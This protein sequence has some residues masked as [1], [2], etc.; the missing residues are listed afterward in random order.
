MGAYIIQVI[1]FQALFLAV[2]YLLLRKET[3]FVYNRIYLLV[4]PVL[5]LAIPFIKIMTLQAIVPA[6][7]MTTVLP[8]VVIG[9]VS[10]APR[11]IASVSESFY[12]P[13]SALYMTGL[14]VS[15]VL[16]SLKIRK[17]AS[18]LSF[19][20]AG[21]RIIEMPASVE[22]FTFFNYIFI[23][24]DIDPLSQKQI[25]IHE[26]IH[27]K[28]GHTWDLVFFELLKIGFW[29]NPLVY[30]YQKHISIVHEYLADQ[31]ATQGIANKDYYQELL[32]TAF[33]TSN[34]SFINTFFKSS[35]IKNR[36]IMLQ[37]SKSRKSAL[38]KYTLIIPLVLA[39]LVYVSCSEDN[40]TLENQTLEQQIAQLQ[41]AIEEKGELSPEEIE[42][43]IE[44][45]T[46]VY[47]K[48]GDNFNTKRF[49][50]YKSDGTWQVIEKESVGDGNG[51]IPFSVIDEV[52][53]YP[54]CEGLITNEERRRCM[55]SKISSHINSRFN[56]GIAD[57]LGISGTNRIFMS[58]K[59]DTDG[60]IVDLKSRAPHP[61]LSS[62]IERIISTLPPMEPGK[63]KGQAASV[64]YTLP[65]TF[66]VE[67]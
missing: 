58:F 64:L 59:I 57:D 34:F 53:V 31:K 15:T 60:N 32:N 47:N 52:P 27:V 11:E 45:N 9:K 43:F 3:F 54:G 1:C 55:S 21:K 28:Q 63:Q 41:A 8:E 14:M 6:E 25:L 62:E 10:V 38:V 19:K 2:Y 61:G 13:W 18:F 29:F 66:K 20:K 22:A 40:E 48:E 35:L 30:V 36:I 50:T 5:S 23:G 65:I 42:K 16:F 17:F 26:H 7:I 67:D 44:M 24:E 33:G 49:F 4:T 12:I 46:F 51:N 39:M 37:K 56:V